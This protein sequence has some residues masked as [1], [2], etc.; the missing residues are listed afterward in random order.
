MY[1]ASRANSV[2]T[3]GSPCV[4]DAMVAQP[5]TGSSSP[6]ARIGTRGRCPNAT[7]TSVV[8]AHPRNTS[9][10]IEI[11]FVQSGSGTSWE[12]DTS[13]RPENGFENAS[14]HIARRSGPPMRS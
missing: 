7:R 2:G 14:V 1:S 11:P 8:A 12:A 10:E 9:D 13:A 4:S 5:V 6:I 3:Y